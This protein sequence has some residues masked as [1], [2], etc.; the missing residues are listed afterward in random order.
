[1]LIL[2]GVSCNDEKY[3]SKENICERCECKNLDAEHYLVDGLKHDNV[4]AFYDLD[5]SKRNFSYVLA[6]WPEDLGD[7]QTGVNLVF[8]LSNNHIKSIQQLPQTFATISFIC[9]NCQIT[10]IVPEAF[11]DTPNIEKLDLSWNKITA[12]DLHP[13]I[14][15]GRYSEKEYET[16]KLE[17]L[18]FSHNKIN[19]LEKNQFEH[20]PHVTFLDL[21][22]NPLGEI[23]WKTAM[24]IGSLYKLEVCRFDYP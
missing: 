6:G 3:E 1:M 14:F 10:K 15:Q 21:S 9:Q 18:D 19:G 24:A 7:N 23:D 2:N 20:V 16:I 17:A 22:Y 4:K 11:I 5:C 12:D 13:N 8:N